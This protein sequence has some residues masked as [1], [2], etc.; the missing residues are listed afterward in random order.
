M[1]SLKFIFSILLFLLCTL[2][3]GGFVWVMLFGIPKSAMDGG[4]L[5]KLLGQMCWRC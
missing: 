1:D 5:V 4:T 3:I 2:L